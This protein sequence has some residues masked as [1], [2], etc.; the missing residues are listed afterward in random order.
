MKYIKNLALFYLAFALNFL[1]GFILLK[2]LAIYV[3]PDILGKYFFLS[4]SGLFVGGLLLL[5]FPLTFQRFIPIYF[6][7]GKDENAYALIHFPSIFHFLVGILVSIP[8][9]ILKG[10]DA[11]LIF[12]A[13]YIVNTITLY[14]TA[15][16]SRVKI[17]EYSLTSFARL[18]TI[19]CLL[20]ISAPLL[21]LRTIGIINLA[22]NFAFLL[23]LF[24][25]FPFKIKPW[26]EVFRETREYWIYS[27]L[28][29]ILSPFFHFFDSLL[30]PIY[31]PYSELS[32]FQIARK[33]DMGAKQ[34]LEVPLQLT[35]PIISFKRT[36]EL[37]TKEFAEKYRA[38]RTFY[39]YLTLL[40]FL[41]FEFF[42]KNLIL[43]VSTNQYLR[44]HP[45]LIVLS[46]SLL[47][48]TLYATD[49]TFARSTGNIKLFFYKDLVWVLTFL[50]AFITLTPKLDLLGV[51]ISF[52]TATIITATFHLYNF[53]VLHPLEY[54]FDALKIVVIGTQAV[55]FITTGKIFLPLLL[56]ILII[57]IDFKQIKMTLSTLKNYLSI[58]KK[59]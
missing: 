22:V 57:G 41:I 1:M 25:L 54:L 42:G 49:A 4:N 14:Q 23:I 26:K 33:L 6:R 55:I 28:T 24:S 9:L 16:I 47:V 32:L 31:L 12:L 21:T 38:F 43:L 39:F 45:H 51:T 5:G 36:D 40:W 29:Q 10:L 37:L 3:P 2:I 8:I 17:L 20:L 48:S 30:I 56:L 18:L 50:L 19:I 34:T 52:L 46:F 58:S 7:D 53:P 59:H 44:A 27:L 11:F 15:L 35:A 13:F